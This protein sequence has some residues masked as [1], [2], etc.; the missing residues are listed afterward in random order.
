MPTCTLVT[1]AQPNPARAKAVLEHGLT[2]VLSEGAS[3]PREYVHIH[4]EGMHGNFQALFDRAQDAAA[5]T[6]EEIR[7]VPRV[8]M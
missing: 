6:Q 5:A 3:V 7:E 2:S 8:L 1:T 4:A